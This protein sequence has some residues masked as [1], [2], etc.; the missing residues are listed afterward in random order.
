MKYRINLHIFFILLACFGIQQVHS[1]KGEWVNQVIVVNSGK[2]EFVPPYLDYVT[3]QAYDPVTRIVKIFDTIY[4]QS[5]QDVVINGHYAY[6]AAQDSIIKYDLDNYQRVAAIADSGMVKLGIYGNKVIVA[7]QY[8][9]KRFFVEILDDNLALLAFVE[10]ISGDCGAVTS[11]LDSIYVAIN[12]GWQGTEG[13]MAVINAT[14]W[15]LMRERNFGTNAIGIWNLY[16]YGGKV[17]SVNKTPYGFPQ[18]GS[19]T[20]YNI[21]SGSVNTNELDYTIGDGAGIVDNLLYLKFDEGIGSY[22]LDTKTVVDPSIIP[23]PGSVNHIYI[24]SSG[25]DYVNNHLYLNLGNRTSNG[26]GVITTLTGDSITSFQEG[27][28]A[29]CI[30]IDY[31]TPV[32]IHPLSG[33]QDPVSVYPNP[34][35]SE[36]IVTINEKEKADLLTVIDLTGRNRIIEQLDGEKKT[37][38]INCESLSAGIYFLSV[39]TGNGIIT[40][41]FIKQ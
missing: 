26:F 16:N 35:N 8:P 30:A 13:R 2:F 38:K 34:V 41:K 24:I 21:Y 14:N 36:L 17:F 37:I 20:A 28:S 9:I 11:D 6:V 40:R 18:V 15:T 4:T 3:V 5:A 29:E 31:R 23:D 27:V 22:N 7:K 12:H 39:K 32:G 1:Q 25:V 33:S 10:G 19:I